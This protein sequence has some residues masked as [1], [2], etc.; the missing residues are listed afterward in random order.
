MVGAGTSSI[1][2][3]RIPIRALIPSEIRRFVWESG[4]WKVSLGVGVWDLLWDLLWDLD[5]DL[6]WDIDYWLIG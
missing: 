5:W 4:S 1:G 2:T 3:F 6:D